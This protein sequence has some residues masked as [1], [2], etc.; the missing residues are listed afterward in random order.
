MK[1]PA[2]VSQAG[3]CWNGTLPQLL[4]HR[5]LCKA[6]LAFYFVTLTLHA[7]PISVVVALPAL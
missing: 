3:V 2:A 4:E 7:I 1:S 6:H 5:P